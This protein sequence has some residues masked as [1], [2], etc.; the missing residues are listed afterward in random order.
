M[1]GREFIP[2]PLIHGYL[3]FGEVKI[4]AKSLL[5]PIAIA[6]IAAMALRA[7]EI[8]L[9]NYKFRVTIPSGWERV[10]QARVSD[11]PSMWSM[12]PVIAA[13]HTRRHLSVAVLVAKSRLTQSVSDTAN[14]NNLMRFI[15][16][17]GFITAETAD[18]TLGRLPAYRIR[19]FVEVDRQ[20]VSLLA[21]IVFANRTAYMVMFTDMDGEDVTADPDVRRIIKS[22][23]FIGAPQIHIH[24]DSARA[25]RVTIRNCNS[26]ILLPAGW[27][28]ERA[29]EKF[30]RNYPIYAAN[31][32]LSKQLKISVIPV[33]SKS[34]LQNDVTNKAMIEVYE[35]MLKQWKY[36]LID[37]KIT[38]V[39]GK[40]ALSFRARVTDHNVTYSANVNVLVSGKFIYMIFV[41]TSE[42]N[43]AS[44]DPEL[45]R[46]IQSF[47]P[48]SG[49]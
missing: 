42:G 13:K 16:S 32:S 44:T 47:Q 38:R 46:L 15:E 41:I 30:N 31:S 10:S 8:T 35:I 22:F 19:G 23:A 9:H 5:L 49:R 11:A 3:D 29:E 20:N 40:R 37:H 27:R 36:T 25:T 18:D 24:P 26:S 2:L 4:A 17:D 43:D 45:Q 14:L 34:S 28:Q 6:L 7:Q 21:L 33:D 1:V 12:M 48:S 39:A